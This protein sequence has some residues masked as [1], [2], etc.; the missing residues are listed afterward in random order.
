[1]FN[2]NIRLR[3]MISIKYFPYLL[4]IFIIY[5]YTLKGAVK[6][7]RSIIDLQSLNSIIESDIYSLPL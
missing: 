4:S 6:K 5:K 1:M 2:K 7:A 3:R